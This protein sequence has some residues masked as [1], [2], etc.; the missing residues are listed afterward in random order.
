MNALAGRP[1]HLT[2]LQKVLRLNWALILLSL[3]HI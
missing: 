3:I 1:V 2:L